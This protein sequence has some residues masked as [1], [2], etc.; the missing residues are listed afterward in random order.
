MGAYLFG[1]VDVPKLESDSSGIQPYD[2]SRSLQ[3]N[4]KHP[5]VAV[6]LG[7]IGSRLEKVR[8][9]L[10]AEQRKA[11]QSEEARRLSAE[12]QKIADILNNDFRDQRRRLNEIRAAAS[13]A[14]V[15]PTQF[16]DSA[17][18][19]NDA[20]LW[21]DGIDEPGEVSKTDAKNH[22]S[23]K[24][25]ARKDPNITSA[26]KQ[27]PDGA[28]T[29]SPAG[30]EGPRHTKPRGGFRVDYRKLGRDE[31]RS[32][33][34]SSTMSILINLDHPVVSAALGLGGVEDPAFRRLS[35]E[36]AF[37]EYAIALSYEMAQRDP[38]V[39]ADDLLYDV[40]TTLNRVARSAAALYI[41]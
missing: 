22:G 32:S 35:Y 13:R 9:E 30:G 5:V 36:I 17:E 31:N 7:F 15:A 14:G 38:D 12:S 19:S 40:R 8:L 25:K 27:T 34:D 26:A 24:A 23:G 29:V 1:E 41:S 20:D 28:G 2:A 39:P 10:V 16:G 33:Y 6:L 37:S 11:R 4:P 18:A 21:V 3:L